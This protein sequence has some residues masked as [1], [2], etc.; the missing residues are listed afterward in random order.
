MTATITVIGNMTADAELRYSQNGLAIASFT[1]A[2][3]E[4]VFD[5][6]INDWKDGKTLFMR[7]TAWREL[8][9]HVAGSLT[10]GTRVIVVGKISTNEYEDKDHN[11]RSSIDLT[12]DSIGPDLKFA[13]AQVTKASSSRPGGGAS[14]SEPEPWATVQPGQSEP[15]TDVWSNPSDSED[16]PF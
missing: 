12:V 5:K 8:A 16:T 6:Q 3:T 1:V 2:S 9:E 13:T 7:C 10:K 11:K 14:A 4:K 15:Q